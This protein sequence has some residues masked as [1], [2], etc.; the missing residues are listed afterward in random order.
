LAADRA[1]FSVTTVATMPAVRACYERGP[2]SPTERVA[3]K[4]HGAQDGSVGRLCAD[5]ET[6]F[7]DEP[8]VRCM[9]EEMCKLRYPEATDDDPRGPLTFSYAVT[10]EP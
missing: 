10:F 4:V 6:T 8:V 7:D 9:L 1:C 3:F 5:A 2:K